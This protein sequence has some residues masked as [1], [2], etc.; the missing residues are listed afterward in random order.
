[1]RQNMM[2]FLMPN[3]HIFAL[4]FNLDDF[5]PQTC[6]NHRSKVYWFK[7]VEKDEWT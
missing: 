1:M 3:Q 4:T 6:K 5:N 2:L 7:R